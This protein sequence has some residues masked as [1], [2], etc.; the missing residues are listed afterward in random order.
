[1]GR[2]GSVG[3]SGRRCLGILPGAVAAVAFALALTACGNGGPM[4]ED[5][6]P[7]QQFAKMEQAL[8]DAGFQAHY[9]RAPKT[10]ADIKKLPQ[11]SLLFHQY[12]GRY[13]YVYADTELCGC[14]Y[15]GNR[16]AYLSYRAMLEQEAISDLQSDAVV[17]NEP[18]ASDWSG[19]GP[20][21]DPAY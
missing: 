16:S 3:L 7:T 1:M 6:Q 8:A 17:L 19:W 10:F 13:R 4:Q 9:A 14:V 21:Y 20:W 18:M 5:D 12:Q 11:H 2:L 15:I